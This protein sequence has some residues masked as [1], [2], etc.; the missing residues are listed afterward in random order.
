MRLLPANSVA[1]AGTTTVRVLTALLQQLAEEAC[2]FCF[3][4]HAVERAD[5]CQK[6]FRW[7][8]NVAAFRHD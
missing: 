2:R 1:M 8:E 4:C 5:A 3:I 6:I 7:K